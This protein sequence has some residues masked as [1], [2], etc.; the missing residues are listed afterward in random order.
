MFQSCSNNAATNK[1][2]L[3]L[4]IISELNIELF[5][6]GGGELVVVFPKVDMP[7]HSIHYKSL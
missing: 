7:K 6:G 3:N 2:L 4:S 5:F 1:H